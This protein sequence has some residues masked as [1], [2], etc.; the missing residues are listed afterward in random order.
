MCLRFLFEEV[1]FWKIYA[2]VDVEDTAALSL[3]RSVGMT[4][5]STSSD[6]TLHGDG[7]WFY[8]YFFSIIQPEWETKEKQAA[9]LPANPS[10][11]LLSQDS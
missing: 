7:K 6:K 9:S 1:N 4:Y 11:P 10:I 8:P 2:H 5:E 3:M